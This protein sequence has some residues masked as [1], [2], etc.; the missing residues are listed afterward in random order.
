[1]DWLETK[2]SSIK[3]IFSATDPL[4]YLIFYAFVHLV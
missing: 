2:Q 1:M 3:D 4:Y